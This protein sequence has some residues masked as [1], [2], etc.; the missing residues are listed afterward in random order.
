MKV[1]IKRTGGFAGLIEELGRAEAPQ[2]SPLEQAV[3]QL[4]SRAG[5]DEHIGADLF[6]YEVRVEDG[7]GPETLVFQDHDPPENRVL[8]DLIRQVQS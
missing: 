5:K 8:R 2:N 7:G 1:S 6:R 3:R 4:K